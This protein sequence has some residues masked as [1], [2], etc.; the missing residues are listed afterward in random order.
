MK[1]AW[2]FFGLPRSPA[3]SAAHF[4]RLMGLY[5]SKVFAHF[6]TCN[7]KGKEIY[8]KREC[9]IKKGQPTVTNSTHSDAI[10]EFKRLY[11]PTKIFTE[12]CSEALLEHPEPSPNLYR[13][14]FGQCSSKRVLSLIDPYAFDLIVKSRTDVVVH[15]KEIRE[16][17]ILN[18]D[19]LHVLGTFIDPN[20]RKYPRVN[21]TFM[22][23]SPVVMSKVVSMVD[24]YW[25]QEEYCKSNIHF[26]LAAHCERN[27]IPVVLVGGAASGRKIG[28]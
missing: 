24:E 2:L 21:D 11:S 5:D 23:G 6:W 26:A 20:G 8:V 19:A 28:K 27:S 7:E 3:F 25:E 16:L 18:S 12:P 9:E 1:V 13:P 17:K 4:S 15:P 22:Y 10:E 14:F